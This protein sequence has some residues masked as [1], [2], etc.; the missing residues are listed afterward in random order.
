[1]TIRRI[2]QI[3]DLHLL[4]FQEDG[5]TPRACSRAR[6]VSLGRAIDPAGR[7]SRALSSIL[8]ARKQGAEH[9]VF[10]GDLTELGLPSEFEVLAALFEAADLS[11]DEVTLVPGNHDRYAAPDD[12]AAALAGPLAPWARSSPAATNADATVVDLGSI[13]L[14]PIDVTRPQSVI[15]SAGVLTI[16]TLESVARR[17]ADSAFRRVPTAIVQHHPPFSLP[18]VVHF[19]DGLLGCER[20]TE[21]VERYDATQVLFG[22]LHR[23]VDRGDSAGLPRWLGAASVTED[24]AAYRLYDVTPSGLAPVPTDRG[25]A[26]AA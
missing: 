4:S 6:F 20:L 14:L 8:R 25:L 26:V 11:S 1:M 13:R 15:R 9:F 24:P 2:A 23:H 10:S 17:L 5:V 18:P 12:W 16:D 21:V 22:H 19:I 7:A 3:S